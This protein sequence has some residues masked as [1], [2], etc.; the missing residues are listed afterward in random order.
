MVC[1]RIGALAEVRTKRGRL[2]ESDLVKQ[3]HV[4]CSEDQADEIC[5]FIFWSAQLDKPGR[6]V[7]WQQALTGCTPYELQPSQS[8]VVAAALHNKRRPP[9]LWSAVAV[10]PL[11]LPVRLRDTR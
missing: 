10:T 8:G 5:D 1:S 4:I 3:V 2:P 6:G 7:M 11:W 9:R